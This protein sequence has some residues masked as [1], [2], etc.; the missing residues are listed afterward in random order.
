M[1]LDKVVVENENYYQNY[2]L[3]LEYS[4]PERAGIHD[5]HGVRHWVVVA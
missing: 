1:P 5:D 3:N 2:L 4:V